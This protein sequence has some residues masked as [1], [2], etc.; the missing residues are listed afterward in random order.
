MHFTVFIFKDATRLVHQDWLP[1]ATNVGNSFFS[2]IWR[3]PQSSVT[4]AVVSLPPPDPAS[5]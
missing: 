5:V 4:A 2:T 3:D 1:A